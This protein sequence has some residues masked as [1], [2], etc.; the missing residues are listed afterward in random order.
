MET[1]S[2]GPGR[3]QHFD[4]SRVDDGPAF[5]V[6]VAKVEE[7]LQILAAVSE[8]SG[9]RILTALKAF[10]MWSLAP[11]IRT[12]LGGACASGLYEA[13]LAEK[14]YLT[15]DSGHKNK[16]GVISV[17]CPAYRSRDIIALREICEHVIFNS[18]SQL[19]KFADMV[20]EKG[21]Q[22]GLRIN[23]ETPLGEVATYDPSA[24]G[25]RLGL[26]ASQFDLALL[27]QIDGLHL[28]NLCEQGLPELQKT[29]AAIR[30][31]LD[32]GKGKLKWVN[33][34]GG[35]M[36]TSPDYDRDGLIDFLSELAAELEAEIILEPGTAIAFDA[37]ILVGEILDIT[38]ND[39]LNAI[40]DI[41][42]T[43]HMPDLLEAPYRPALLGEA[44]TGI[45]V[46]F[47]GPSCLAGDVIG[48]YCLA[49]MPQI[50]DRIAFLDQAH[51]SMVKTT[52]FNGVP[53]PAIMLWDSR[54]DSV[55]TIR[56]FSFSDFEGRLS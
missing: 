24:S 11:L 15:K 14:Y 26:P 22:I 16:D 2:A 23:P 36:I 40:V 34:G 27:D 32:A 10:S 9:A 35:H 55:Q 5:V 21:G 41:S 49:S 42:A 50:G 6:D 8:A 38:E 43:C 17:F 31:I 39:G 29:V 1:K 54:D 19:E 47:G 30:P 56:Q 53:L 45:W 44:D 12:Y 13:Q 7:N 4:L 3:F 28:H 37:G 52:M 20:R 48:R 25:S 33:L 46:R 18:P 51:Y